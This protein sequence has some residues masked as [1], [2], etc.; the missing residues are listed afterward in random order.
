MKIGFTGAGGTGKTTLAKTLAAVTGETFMPSP[1][2][3][4]FEKHGVKSEDDQRNMTP[5]ARYALQ[6]DIFKAINTQVMESQNGVFDR[7][8][9]DNLF[10]GFWQCRERIS[11]EQFR[12]MWRTT[13]VGLETFDFVIFCPMYQW[14]YTDATTDGMRT[15]SSVART[16]MDHFIYAFLDKV[17]MNGH[18]IRL[19][20]AGDDTN[21]VRARE[22]LTI[23]EGCS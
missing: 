22:I 12:D 23:I 4:C 16:V 21:E 6:M 13:V 3:A 9:L 5:E 20:K 2:R 18:Q 14:C 1:S 15:Q 11:N 19:I 7:T 10:Y 8:H 17:H